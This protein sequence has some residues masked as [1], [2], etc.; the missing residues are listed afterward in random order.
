MSVVPEGV[1]FIKECI[2]KQ[3]RPGHVGTEI[4]VP[5]FRKNYK[6]DP[7]RALQICMNRT[8]KLRNVNKLFISY[9]KPHGSVSGQTISSLSV[10]VVKQAYDNSHLKINAHST[11]A[12]GA[13]WAILKVFFCINS[14]S[15][16]LEQGLCVLRDFIIDS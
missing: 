6:L 9:Q 2:A 1:I 3:D 12:I 5:C 7:K 16:R 8:S 11:R 13:S 15:C 4:I 10:N 14:G